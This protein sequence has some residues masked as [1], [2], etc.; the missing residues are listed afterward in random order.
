ML[1]N[2]LGG[3][4]MTCEFICDG[5][6]KREKGRFGFFAWVLPR[7]WHYLQCDRCHVTTQV[8]C[9]RECVKKLAELTRTTDTC[10][11]MTSEEI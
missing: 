1:A 11:Q 10:W 9:S 6:G 2:G 5:C 8:A 7:D 3:Y 4:E